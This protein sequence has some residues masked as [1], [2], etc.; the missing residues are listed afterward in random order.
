MFDSYKSSEQMTCQSD[1]DSDARLSQVGWESAPFS[2]R[3]AL[4]QAT[5]FPEAVAWDRVALDSFEQGMYG[6]RWGAVF[7]LSCLARGIRAL[8]YETCSGNYFQR[9]HASM[10]TAYFWIPGASAWT[11]QTGV[12]F[13]PH[14]LISHRILRTVPAG[15][16]SGH[17]SLST[18]TK[19]LVYFLQPHLHRL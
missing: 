12:C 13:S 15:P 2:N 14:H 5:G 8:D 11:L 10:V 6:W 16:G 1:S 4:N 7:D 3:A 19:W 17:V 9:A 18:G